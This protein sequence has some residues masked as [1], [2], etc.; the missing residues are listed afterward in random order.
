MPRILVMPFSLLAVIFVLC[1]EVSNGEGG[2]PTDAVKETVERLK[3]AV[4][5]RPLIQKLILERMDFDEM[6]KRS[7]G[8]HWRGLRPAEKK[9]YLDL[10]AKYVEVFYR[11]RVFESVEFLESVD[12]KYLRQ[13][14]DDEFAEVDV[15]IF[16]RNN[17]ISITFKLHLVDEQ[18]KTYDLVAENISTVSNL[19]SQ[20]DRIVSQ[21]SFAELLNR[22]R[23]KIEELDK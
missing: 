15:Q 5:N 2:Q 1:L 20:F 14:I 17:K 16:A 6:G 13:R 10:F 18:W 3:K 23:E 7:L 9:E 4:G 12:I 19:R 8:R 21:Y 22:L 11:K